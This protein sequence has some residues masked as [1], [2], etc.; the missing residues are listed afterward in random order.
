MIRK[1][2]FVDIIL[3]SRAAEDLQASLRCL[4]PGG[5]FLEIE[6]I[7]LQNNHALNLQ[8]FTNG[9]S[10]SGVMMDGLFCNN[11]EAMRKISKLLSNGLAKGY[12]KPLNRKLFNIDEVE[13][14]YRYM[15]EANRTEKVVIKIRETENP[16]T[17]PKLYSALPK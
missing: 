8:M 11:P 16:F 12:V 2:T 17:K 10:F 6:Q 7:N 1:H 3:N 13:K 4:A 5:H 9:C 15:A 14:A